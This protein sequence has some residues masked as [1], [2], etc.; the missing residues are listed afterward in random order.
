MRFLSS[1]ARIGL[2]LAATTKDDGSREVLLAARDGGVFR[3]CDLRDTFT[4]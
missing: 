3:F 4:G 2:V 1:S